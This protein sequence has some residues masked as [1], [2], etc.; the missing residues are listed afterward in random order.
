MQQ[1][2]ECVPNFS[3]GNDMNI[4]KQIRAKYPNA[5]PSYNP[6]GYCVGGACVLFAEIETR[7][8]YPGF[9]FSHT[10]AS[11]LQKLNSSLEPQEAQTF[12][13]CIMTLNDSGN[14]EQAW[15][16]AELAVKD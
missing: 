5:Q 8:C 13:L 10:I 4:I 2:I 9:P 3:E 7:A 1:L 16:I 11:A 6:D 15:K 12:A 14:I